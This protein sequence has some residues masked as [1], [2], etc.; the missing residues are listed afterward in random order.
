MWVNGCIGPHSS[1]N[2][3]ELGGGG[4]TWEGPVCASD[5]IVRDRMCP[6][7]SCARV[8]D[9]TQLLSI[10]ATAVGL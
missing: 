9:H 3:Y 6:A 10:L 5:I 1:E 7:T 4:M 2:V 8:D